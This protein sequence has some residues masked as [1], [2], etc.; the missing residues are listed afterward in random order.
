MTCLLGMRAWKWNWPN[1]GSGVAEVSAGELD[2]LLA[3]RP[4]PERGVRNS[5]A[6]CPLDGARAG[7]AASRMG[8]SDPL[9]SSPAQAGNQGIVTGI[10]IHKNFGKIAAEIVENA[11][12]PEKCCARE[13]SKLS[14]ECANV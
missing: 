8:K 9:R 5:A 7:D 2:C 4:G 10:S 3:P 11:K 12:G 14:G 6:L 1:R 13:E